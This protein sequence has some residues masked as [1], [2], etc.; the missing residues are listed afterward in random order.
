MKTLETTVDG[1]RSTS[2]L[3]LACGIVSSISYIDFH[4]QDDPREKALRD[5]V[6]RGI[7]KRSRA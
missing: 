4:L 1:G 2:R 7:G 6:Y 3:L 5:A